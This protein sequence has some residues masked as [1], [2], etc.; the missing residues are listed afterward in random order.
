MFVILHVV[1]WEVTQR[2]I[3][4]RQVWTAVLH[5]AIVYRLPW[6]CSYIYMGGQIY[7]TFGSLQ[8]EFVEH[9][10][11]GCLVAGHWAKLATAV[12]WALW[13]G[14]VFSRPQAWSTREG[15]NVRICLSLSQVS[16]LHWWGDKPRNGAVCS[17]IYI[18]IATRRTAVQTCLCEIFR[19]ITSQATTWR[20]TNTKFTWLYKNT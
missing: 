6:S 3:S 1:A 10:T 7:P 8:P 12:V 13:H 2:K 19:S 11:W 9:S 14:M 20:I 15:I 5:V 18:Y 17:Y 4:Q 16:A